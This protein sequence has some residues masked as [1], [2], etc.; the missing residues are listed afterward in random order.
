MQPSGG[1]DVE[2]LA[3]EVDLRGLEVVVA[4][5]VGEAVVDLAGLG[6]DEIGRERP[7]VATEQRVGQRAVTPG[8]TGEVQPHDEDRERVDQPV[9]RVG[10]QRRGEQCAIGQGE[11]QVAGHDRG[12]Q[13]LAVRGGAPSYDADR[14]DAGDAAT[15]ELE[16]QVVLVL[17]DRLDRLLH[18]VDVAGQADEAHDVARDSPWQSDDRRLRPVFQRDVPGEEQQ[19]VLTG[20]SGDSQGHARSFGGG[21]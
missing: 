7:C 2:H 17:G 11:L 8:E 15:P 12:G 18:G 3:A 13:L 16:E 20:G 9:G 14:I 10:T 1:L 21:R 6:I 4:L 5:A 19:V